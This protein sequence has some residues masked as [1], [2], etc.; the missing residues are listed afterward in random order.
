MTVNLS[1]PNPADILP[2]P[3]VRLGIAEAGIRK[4]G[5]KDLTVILLDEGSAVS[6][7]FTQN[8]YCAAPV[9]VA[10]ARFVECAHHD[11]RRRRRRAQR[12]W[13]RYT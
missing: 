12:Q 6:G 2:V 1:A 7:V 10:A 4:V 5:R 13:C 9:Q 11:G 3:G 8:R